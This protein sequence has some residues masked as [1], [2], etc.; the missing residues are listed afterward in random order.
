MIAYRI[1][2]WRRS[3]AG[4]I[5]PLYAIAGGSE[6]AVL[7]PQVEVVGQPI[8]TIPDEAG[9]AGGDLFTTDPADTV[10]QVMDST[11]IAGGA[12]VFSAAGFKVGSRVTL[13]TRL[14][15][16]QFRM[17]A[18]VDA[19]FG[20]SLD[21]STVVFVGKNL[22]NATTSDRSGAVDAAG[23]GGVQRFVGVDGPN[24]N[25]RYYQPFIPANTDF[26]WAPPNPE[27]RFT[28]GAIPQGLRL[29]MGAIAANTAIRV[30]SSV[31]WRQTPTP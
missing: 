15:I 19:S 23:T 10:N 1:I 12:G 2:G 31:V 30:R 21:S 7:K 20:V 4:L 13:P 11:Q 18:D 25:L 26:V 22:V 24:T 3:R 16:V 6:L 17:R 5:L 27:F 9:S 14:D 28:P 29:M 8:R